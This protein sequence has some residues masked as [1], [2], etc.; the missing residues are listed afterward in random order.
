M[1]MVIVEM[2]QKK[3][4]III[5][6]IILGIIGSI[7][8][9]I[10]IKNDNTPPKTVILKDNLIFEINTDVQL[11]SLVSENNEVDILSENE[12]ID[13]ST[14]GEKEVSIKYKSKKKEME[15]TF[16]IT[17]VDTTAPT[18]E[19]EKELSTVEGEAIDLLKDVK[20]NDNSNE[21][22]TPTVEGEYDINQNGVYNLKYVATD[23]SNNKSEENFTLTVKEKPIVPQVQV[24]SQPDAEF[25]TT[26]GFSGYTRNGLTYI[27]GVLIANKTYSLPSNYGPGLTSE[28]LSAFNQM[29][30]DAAS[31]GLNIYI[32]SGFR[33]YWTQDS[34]YNNY[35][36]RDG[37]QNA[38]R[39]SARPGHSEHQTGL[40]IDINSVDDAFAYTEE[41]KWL[42]A[43]S[44][45]YGFILR[46]PADGEE[47]TGYMYEP[48]HFRYVG[49]DLATKLYNN[50]DWITLEEYFGITSYYQ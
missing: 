10:K 49:V 21:E 38:D 47:I 6:F 39:Y 36:Y 35:V 26:K 29:K 7:F 24:Y 15:K 31:V 11:L 43:N 5:I 23:S 28:T 2:K 33:S 32:L 22:I 19:C 25:T 30:S 37:R 48:W 41:A 50:E 1:Y 16:I 42:S 13:T 45:K 40:A 14:L 3:F 8:L 44:Y 20:V 4:I 34:I 27:D 18:I 12:K 46:Y 17:I 9:G